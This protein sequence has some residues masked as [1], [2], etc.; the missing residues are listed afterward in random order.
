MNQAEAI[1]IVQNAVWT[2]VAACG[3]AVAAAMIVG[4]VIALFQALTQI[5]E[6]TL[7]F[8]P[9]ILAIFVVIAMTASFTGAQVYAFTQESYSRIETGFTN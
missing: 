9:K 8:V 2:I 4:V 6:V 5:Q 3:P 7:T 1:E